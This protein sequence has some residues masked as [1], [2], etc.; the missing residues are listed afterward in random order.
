MFEDDTMSANTIYLWTNRPETVYARLQSRAGHWL[1]EW[2]YRDPPGSDTYLT[3]GKRETSVRA[4]AEQWL[5][6]HVRV[7]SNE[8]GE[9][10]QLAEKLSAALAQTELGGLEPHHHR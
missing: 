9:V 1:V 4:D 5:L 7:L 10:E 8:P 6:D 2:G 3:Q